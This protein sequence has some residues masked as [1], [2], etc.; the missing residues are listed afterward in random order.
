MKLYLFNV[1]EYLLS[2][3]YACVPCVCLVP[4]EGYRSP[5]DGIAAAAGR[6]LGIAPATEDAPEIPSLCSAF[7]SLLL[8]QMWST[9]PGFPFTMLGIKLGSLVCQV[10]APPLNYTPAREGKVD[11]LPLYRGG[12]PGSV[13]RSNHLPGAVQ[14][15]VE[16]TR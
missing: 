12:N 5:G 13:R 14:S 9:M 16:W 2:C 6:V 1:R 10:T 7:S 3:M 11:H 15:V 8:L 4:E